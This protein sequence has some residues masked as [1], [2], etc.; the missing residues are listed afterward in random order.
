MVTPASL[1]HFSW[2]FKL[3]TFIIVN[4]FDALDKILRENYSL[5]NCY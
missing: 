5:N 3:G 1:T 4:V 2:S